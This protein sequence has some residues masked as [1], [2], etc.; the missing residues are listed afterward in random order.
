MRTE[1]TDAEVGVRVEA[2]GD[3]G[4][5]G[6]S[7]SGDLTLLEDRGY[8]GRSLGAT[9]FSNSA[10]L[11][12]ILRIMDDCDG[13]IVLGFRQIE[14]EQ[15][16]AK[17]G[18]PSASRLEKC[19]FSTPWNQIEASLAYARGLPVMLIREE[20]DLGRSLRLRGDRVFRARGGPRE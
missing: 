19:Y 9:D 17:P 8:D 10:P 4:A 3:D 5:A 14:V 1:G 16:T 6:G 7:L 12:A 11:R 2:H 18:T 13:A 15:G 20:G